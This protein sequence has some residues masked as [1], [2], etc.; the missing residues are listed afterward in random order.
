MPGPSPPFPW[1]L[2]NP[3]QS[4]Q[5]DLSSTETGRFIFQGSQVEAVSRHAVQPCRGGMERAGMRASG[6][7][8]LSDVMTKSPSG[9]GDDRVE[10][11]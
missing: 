7:V 8:S 3:V 4:I 2:A 10:V 6:G 1:P 9:G 5:V 11:G